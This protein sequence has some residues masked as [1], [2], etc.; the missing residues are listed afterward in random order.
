LAQAAPPAI[1]KAVLFDAISEG[2]GDS[3]ELEQVIRYIVGQRDT[4]HTVAIRE[5]ARSVWTVFS[6]NQQAVSRSSFLLS[7]G[8]GDAIIA[9]CLSQI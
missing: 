2:Q 7:G 1:D 9:N 8:L 6:N 3:V 5:A 4:V